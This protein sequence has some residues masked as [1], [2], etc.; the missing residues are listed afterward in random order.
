MVDGYQYINGMIYSGYG[1]YFFL[2]N[3]K[4]IKVGITTV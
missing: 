2:L 4:M 3:D 1:Q